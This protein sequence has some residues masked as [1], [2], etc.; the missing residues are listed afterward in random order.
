[1][2]LPYAPINWT[3]TKSPSP[4]TH[5]TDPKTQFTGLRQHFVTISMGVPLLKANKTASNQHCS[6]NAASRKGKMLL[7]GERVFSNVCHTDSLGV[8]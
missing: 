2:N 8:F 5:P 4:K 1:M 7:E 3:Y 6:R